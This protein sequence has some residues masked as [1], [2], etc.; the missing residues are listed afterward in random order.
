M[1]FCFFEFEHVHVLY[2]YRLDMSTLI[3][4]VPIMVVSTGSHG[5]SYFKKVYQVWVCAREQSA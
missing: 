1:F 3:I 2:T 5:H 4:E